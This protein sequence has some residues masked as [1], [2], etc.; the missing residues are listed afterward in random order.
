MDYFPTHCPLHA[1]FYT[2]LDAGVSF[3]ALEEYIFNDNI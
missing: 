3:V 2:W 1:I